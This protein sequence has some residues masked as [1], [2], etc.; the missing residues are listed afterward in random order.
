VYNK[1]NGGNTQ[2]D[3][4]NNADGIYLYRLVSE[5]SDLISTGKL[6]IQKL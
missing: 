1:F 5:T 3:L 4:S 6:I 2:I